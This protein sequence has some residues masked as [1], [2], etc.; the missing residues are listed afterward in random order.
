MVACLANIQW[1]KAQM[2]LVLANDVAPANTTMKQVKKAAKIAFA[3]D[4][5]LSQQKF[6][7]L[8]SIPKVSTNLLVSMLH[9][10]N[11]IL[12]YCMLL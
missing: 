2:L 12:V 3:V 1:P 10:V 7:N 11:T 6:M 8:Q 9:K 4:M 5:Q